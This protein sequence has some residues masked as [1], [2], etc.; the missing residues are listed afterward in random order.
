MILHSYCECREQFKRNER[1]DKR[2]SSKHLKCMSIEQ[3]SEQNV[4]EVSK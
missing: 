1:F 4:E 2:K 3:I